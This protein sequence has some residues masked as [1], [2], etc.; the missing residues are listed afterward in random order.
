MGQVY[1]NIPIKN[2]QQNFYISR[3]KATVNGKHGTIFWDKHTA[4][5]N[6]F[7]QSIIGMV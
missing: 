1:Y 4:G 3:L 6:R 7:A 2:I 5:F